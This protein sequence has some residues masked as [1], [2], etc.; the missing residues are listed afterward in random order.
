VRVSFL[1]TRP[2]AESQ[3]VPGVLLPPDAVV[4]RDGGT[5]VFV[6]RDGSVE[7]RT[8]KLGSDVGKLR[9][10]TQGVKSGE[11]VVVSPPAELKQGSTIASKE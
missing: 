6:V 8:V 1:A 9:L 7:Q 4:E 11:T 10:A 5:V 3:P 2:K